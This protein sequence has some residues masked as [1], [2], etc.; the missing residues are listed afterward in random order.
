MSQIWLQVQEE[1]TKF[2]EYGY[3]LT[4]LVYFWTLPG[5]KLFIVRFPKSER[6]SKACER[7]LTDLGRY[8][9]HFFLLSLLFFSAALYN[10][11]DAESER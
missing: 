6:P 1:S 8:G 9:T 5:P 3:W 7:G 11:Y 10:K 4:T 2:E